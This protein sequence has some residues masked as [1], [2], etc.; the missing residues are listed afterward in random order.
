MVTLVPAARSCGRKYHDIDRHRPLDRPGAAG[1]VGRT[2][3]VQES[4][5]CGVV[6]RARSHVGV[7]TALL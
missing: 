6:W 2:V 7:E 1:L 4:G 5:H 3:R